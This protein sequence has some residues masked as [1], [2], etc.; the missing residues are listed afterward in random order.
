MNGNEKWNKYLETTFISSPGMRK[1][2]SRGCLK[3]GTQLKLKYAST[4]VRRQFGILKYKQWG[5]LWLKQSQ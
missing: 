4:D 3:G 2:N 5:F 1:K